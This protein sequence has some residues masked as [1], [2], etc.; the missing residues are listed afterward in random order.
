MSGILGWVQGN[1][2]RTAAIATVLI[3]WLGPIGV[4]D[5]IVSGLLTI[6]GILVGTTLVHNAVTPVAAVVETTRKAAADAAA[7]VASRLDG[8]TVGQVGVI[9]DHAAELATTAAAAAADAALRNLGVS[10]KARAA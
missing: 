8:E 5:Y 7:Q 2:A 9:T 4:P 3:G 1:R 6:L 10:R